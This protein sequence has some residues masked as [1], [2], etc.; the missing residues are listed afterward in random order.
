[1]MLLLMGYAIFKVVQINAWR[2]AQA[3]VFDWTY[4]G[5]EYEKQPLKK[6]NTPVVPPE[7]GGQKRAN[8][9]VRPLAGPQF[10]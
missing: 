8:L 5:F 6:A 3:G 9:P 2:Y 4:T 1:L 7:P 10:H